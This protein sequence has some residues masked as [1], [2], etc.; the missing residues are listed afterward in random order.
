MM[1]NKKLTDSFLRL[2]GRLKEMAAYLLKYDNDAEDALQEAFCK[3]WTNRENA[4][5]SVIDGFAVTVVRRICINYLRR[6]SVRMASDIEDI[7]IPDE[8]SPS[9]VWDEEEMKAVSNK[10]LSNLSTL[11]REVFEMSAKGMDNDIIALRLGISNAAVRQNLCRSR[12][13]LINEYRKL[14]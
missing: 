14:Q 7:S 12:K 5:P 11:Q 6:R 2:R 9:Y 3:I 8:S 1:D 4:D 13:I 10:L